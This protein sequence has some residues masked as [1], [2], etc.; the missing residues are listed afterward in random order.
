MQTHQKTVRLSKK[1]LL[2]VNSIIHKGMH[3]SRVITR[4]RILLRSHEGMSKSQIS[5]ELDVHQSTVRR[6]RSRYHASGLSQALYDDPRSGRPPK[7]DEHAEAYLVALACSDPPEGHDH[8]TLE[9]LQRQMIK[10]KQ[11]K[12][13][14]TVALWKRM[15][16][17]DLKPWREKNV[18]HPEYNP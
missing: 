1:S 9:L 5:S 13:I 4:A 11:V 7:L 3:P 10:D 14:S 2:Q 8:W 12:T 15:R 17:H 6:V 18:V 16:E